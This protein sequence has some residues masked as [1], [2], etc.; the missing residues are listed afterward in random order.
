MK[1]LLTEEE[2][3]LCTEDAIDEFEMFLE[4]KEE[5]F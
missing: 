1:L 2:T 5:V 4:E 3:A